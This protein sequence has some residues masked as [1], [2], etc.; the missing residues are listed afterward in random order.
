MQGLGA[1]VLFKFFA[2][3]GWVFFVY[4]GASRFVFEFNVARQ[5]PQV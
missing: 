4:R 5:K 3:T 2:F 1:C